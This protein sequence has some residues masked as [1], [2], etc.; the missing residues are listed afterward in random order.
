M[1]RRHSSEKAFVDLSDFLEFRDSEE[2]DDL[3]DYD[4]ARSLVDDGLTV[5][6]EDDIG[7]EV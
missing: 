3:T 5:V 7:Q 2:V 6:S 4:E 1:S